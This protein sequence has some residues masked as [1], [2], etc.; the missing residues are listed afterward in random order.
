MFQSKNLCSWAP[1]VDFGMFP[2]RVSVS[3]DSIILDDSEFKVFVQMEPD[4][5]SHIKQKIIE[6]YTY[7]DV[8]LC[9]DEDLLNLPNSKLLLFGTCWVNHLTPPLKDDKNKYISFLTSSKN[10]TSGH[11]FRHEIYNKIN[12][13]IVFKKMTP[14]RIENKSELLSDFKYSIVVENEYKNNWFTEKLVDCFAS[15]TIPIYH[16]CPNINNY[17]NPNGIIKFNN[18]NELTSIINTIK[19]EDLYFK[20][21]KEIEENYN[22]CLEYID[23]WDR[24][25]EKVNKEIKND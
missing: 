1:H 5:I 17:F 24:I 4:S 8:I 7:Y 2:K 22:R 13:P 11:K 9:W 6:N 10:F 19:K 25:R 15:K 16:G 14:P 3:V 20:K 12:D 23:I 21:Y 18:I